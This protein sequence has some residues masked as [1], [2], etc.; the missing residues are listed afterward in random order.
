[1]NDE[2]YDIQLTNVNCKKV[3]WASCNTKLHGPFAN[4]GDTQAEALGRL[5]IDVEALGIKWPDDLK[6]VI[7]SSG[8]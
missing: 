3:W 5:K 8:R 4:R 7:I 1:M 6:P 2:A